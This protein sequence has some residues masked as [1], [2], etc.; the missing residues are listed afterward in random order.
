MKY[1]F[2][3]T[4]DA[5][6]KFCEN[7]YEKYYWIAEYHN[8][9]SSLCYIIVGIGII[10]TTRLK[11]LGK[12]LCGVGIGAGLL[13]ATLRHWAQM[14][15]EMAMLILSFYTLKELRPRTSRYLLYPM[16]ISYCLFSRYFIVFFLTFA[17][18]QLL[19]AKYAKEKINVKNKKWI[20]LYFVSFISGL[21]CWF[22][23]QFC[24]T[25]YGASL[26]PYQFHAWW[27]LFTSLA[28]AFGFV[29][30]DD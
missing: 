27:H 28:I 17:G 26:E 8:T 6:V 18:L 9:I 24:R 10:L 19:T 7:K 4:P 22:L 11:L 21:I 20:L 1:A 15:D 3:G 5:S 12:L 30:L 14:G 13:H 23:D 29:A 25:S 2:W 16:L